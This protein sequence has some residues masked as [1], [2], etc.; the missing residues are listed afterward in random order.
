MLNGQKSRKLTFR[1]CRRAQEMLFVDF[2]DKES[3]VKRKKKRPHSPRQ[4]R[5]QGYERNG[6]RRSHQV[7]SCAGNTGRGWPTHAIERNRRADQSAKTDRAP[8]RQAAG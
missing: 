1:I 4:R 6:K 2:R 3:I 7:V 5:K 8:Y